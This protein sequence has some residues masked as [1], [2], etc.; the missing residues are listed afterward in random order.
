MKAF[1]LINPRLTV[2][3]SINRMPRTTDITFILPSE[4][5][6]HLSSIPLLLRWETEALLET[7]ITPAKSIVDWEE[8]PS[9]HGKSDLVSEGNVALYFD[10]EIPLEFTSEQLEVIVQLNKEMNEG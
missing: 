8:V 7:L 10:A 4:S 1:V 3:I 2:E 6:R 5:W 9:L